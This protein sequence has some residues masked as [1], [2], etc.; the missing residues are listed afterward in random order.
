MNIESIKKKALEDKVPIVRD[1]TF[2]V[3]KKI[4]LDNNYKR[5]RI[6]NGN[7]IS[8]R[9]NKRNTIRYKFK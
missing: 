2:E 4:I 5:R 8:T 6:K 9:H 3:M 7:Q 1:D